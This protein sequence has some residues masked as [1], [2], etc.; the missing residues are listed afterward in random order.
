MLGSRVF[1][2]FVSSTFTDFKAERDLLQERVFDPLKEH[3]TKK[4]SG[5][6]AVDLRWGIGQEASAGQ[7]TMRICLSELE[8]CRQVSP[9]PNFVLLLGDR[10]GWRPLPEVVD[11]A[12]FGSVTAKLSTD[13][14]AAAKLAYCRDENAVPAAYVLAPVKGKPRYDAGALRAALEVAAREAGLDDDALVKYTASATE[15]E[16]V[17]GALRVPDA[18]EHVFCFLRSLSGLPD[19]VPAFD[20]ADKTEPSP[21][22]PVFFADYHTDGS[23]DTDAREH[24]D[25]LKSRLRTKLGDHVFDYPAEWSSAGVSTDHVEQLCSDMLES[26]KSVIDA[27]MA[28]LEAKDHLTTE[29]EAHKDFAAQRAEGFVGRA[30]YL[31]LIAEYLSSD[32]ACPLAIYSEGGMGKSALMARALGDAQAAHPDAVFVSRF[33]G[34]TSASSDLRSLLSDVCTEIGIAYGNTE[35]VPTTVQ[36]LQQELPERLKLATSDQPLIVFLDS[37]DQLSASAGT[38]LSWLPTDLPEHVRLVTTTRPGYGKGDG[39]DAQPGS[40]LASLRAKLPEDQVVELGAMPLEEGGEALDGWLAAAKPERKLTAAQRVEVLERFRVTGSPLYLRLACE[41]AK[42]WPSSLEFIDLGE[43]KEQI[44]GNLYE[45][46]E[47]EHGAQLVAHA[48]GFLTVSRNRLG[49]SEDELLDALATDKATWEEFAVAAKWKMEERRLPAIVWS[50]LYFDLEHYLSPRTSEDASLL[51]FFHREMG[52]VA[53]DRY[54]AGHAKEM[55]E[56]LADVFERQAK[57]RDPKEREWKGTDH[58]LAELPFHLTGAERW[59]G[60][61]AT[62]TDF[63]YLEEKARRVAVVAAK[64]AEGNDA[65]VYNGVL[66]LID[67]YDRALATFPAE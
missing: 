38:S 5:F 9:K 57:G 10:Y 17:E 59:D 49:L 48:L 61:F 54:V 63:T 28:D 19:T 64:D 33:I 16:I 53:E 30:N 60:V 2:V 4:H 32:A 20:P 21:T 46:L 55:H 52:E 1:R 11:A 12:E 37:L 41:E 43:T 31:S 56:V 27:Q 66:S 58:A 13:D 15:Q 6:Q 8:R 23:P 36:E 25:D 7:R 40:F 26:L 47:R 18:A 50:R 22:D 44:I 67:D 62:L 14:G 45:R 51:A 3:C 24:L 42:L 34:V 39:D 29:R 35:P 65:T